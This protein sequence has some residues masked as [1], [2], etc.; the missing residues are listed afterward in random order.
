MTPYNEC[1]TKPCAFR[2]SRDGLCY[3]LATPCAFHAQ[4]P[5]I[6]S[7]TAQLREAREVELT[8]RTRVAYL[9][10]RQAYLVE[11]NAKT[12]RE[13]EAL[14]AESE[15]LRRFVVRCANEAYDSH[16]C[17]NWVRPDARHVLNGD[18]L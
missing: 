3:E 5:V 9:E 7:L 18:G 8:L 16:D 17:K 4:Q 15:R 13:R 11:T 1:P 10:G 14:R 2:V 12:Q 6:T